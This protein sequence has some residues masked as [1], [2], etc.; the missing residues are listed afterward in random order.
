MRRKSPNANSNLKP[1]EIVAQEAPITA[2]QPIAEQMARLQI[3]AKAKPTTSRLI[4]IGP[5]LAEHILQTRNLSN[6][7]M[8]PGKIKDYAA[9]LRS[10]RWGMT[11]D[12]IK[13]ASDGTLKDGQNRLAAVIRAHGPILR[14]H[15]VFGVDADLFT[16]MDIGK[17][18][19]PADV[20]HIAGLHYPA[21]AAATVRW[22]NIL[23]SDNP[24]NRGAHF[25]N[26][27]LLE[28]YRGRYDPV[29][30]EDSVR[31]ALEVKKGTGAPVGAMAALHYI[32]A[33]ADGAE[34]AT[35]F[36]LEWANDQGSARS[37]TRQL[38]TRL[39][40]LAIQ[41]NNRI[42]ESVRNALV[43]QAYL[44]Y[45][46]G[47]PITRKDLQFEPG[48]DAFPALPRPDETTPAPKGSHHAA[49][50]A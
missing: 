23:T 19:T 17:N 48:E 1:A 38:Q 6:R 43:V 39:Q 40:E 49:K 42:H 44:A 7:P 5:E 36:F 22:L 37:A 46:D 35:S 10:G 30:I 20:F 8:K 4:E 24:N 50:A 25:T 26:D 21:H 12:T 9:D 18:R 45:R 32:F 34:K 16:R 27:E 15:A 33:K 47:K 2:S 14:T 3:L 31:V 41:T 11:G 29:L 13:F 28:A